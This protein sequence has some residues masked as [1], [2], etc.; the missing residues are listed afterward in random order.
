M[1]CDECKDSDLGPGFLPSDWPCGCSRRSSSGSS[2]TIKKKLSVE[3]REERLAR[4]E[5]V[6]RFHRPERSVREY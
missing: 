5:E 3:D 6:G 2:V 4:L 1:G